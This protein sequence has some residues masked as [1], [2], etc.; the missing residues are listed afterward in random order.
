MGNSRDSEENR[1]KKLLNNYYLI[2]QHQRQLR[3]GIEREQN[4]KHVL[5]IQRRAFIPLWVIRSQHSGQDLLGELR[6]RRRQL[7]GSRP[8]SVHVLR[9]L[10]QDGFE[11]AA[12]RS[13]KRHP[14]RPRWKVPLL[15]L[16][17][18]R[19]DVRHRR[20]GQ[21]QVFQSSPILQELAAEER[22]WSPAKQQRKRHRGRGTDERPE[23]VFGHKGLRRH[24]EAQAGRLP[25][26]LN[27]L[28]SRRQ[29]HVPDLRPENA[30]SQIQNLSPLGAAIRLNQED[31]SP[32]VRH[33]GVNK[34]LL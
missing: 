13:T 31:C 5:R 30:R 32:R 17:E 22:D 18:Q 3:K 11:P 14:L 10:W 16:L 20:Q 33:V 25:T 23:P 21:S 9:G 8:P 34:E 29:G 27:A 2:K 4:G 28:R 24:N 15:L 7:T 1:S 6:R 26:I 12:E 19:S